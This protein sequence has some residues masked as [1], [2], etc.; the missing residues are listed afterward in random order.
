MKGGE[1]GVSVTARYAFLLG[2]SRFHSQEYLI[3]SGDNF[4]EPF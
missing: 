3:L 4:L 1:P 2:G